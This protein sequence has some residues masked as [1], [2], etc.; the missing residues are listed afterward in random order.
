MR[1]IDSKYHLINCLSV[2]KIDAFRVLH[3]NQV[4]NVNATK[5]KLSNMSSVISLSRMQNLNLVIKYQTKSTKG[6]YKTVGM[7]PSKMPV[8]HWS[9]IGTSTSKSHGS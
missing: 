5:H 6:N 9:K 3:L 4:A 2:T 8:L 1:G 7:N